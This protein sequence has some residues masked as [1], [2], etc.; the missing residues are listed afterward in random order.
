MGCRTAAG[1]VDVEVAGLHEA[2]PSGR[3]ERRERRR[4]NLAVGESAA[5]AQQPRSPQPSRLARMVASSNPRPHQ[6]AHHAPADPPARRRRIRAYRSTWASSS[7]RPGVLRGDGWHRPIGEHAGGDANQSTASRRLPPRRRT[8]RSMASPAMVTG[9][10]PP[11]LMAVAVRVH[12]DRRPVIVVIGCRAMPAPTRA[13]AFSRSRELVEDFVEAGATTRRRSG[14]T[15]GRLGGHQP[16]L[17]PSGD[18]AWS[19]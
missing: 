4:R 6:P 8:A 13:V 15:Q 3:V 2:D 17:S 12:R 18:M 14:P 1:G 10:A 7:P 9:P 5:T 19:V 16:C 11:T